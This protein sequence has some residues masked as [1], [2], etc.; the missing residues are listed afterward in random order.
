MET[1]LVILGLGSSGDFY[2]QSGNTSSL[3]RVRSSLAQMASKKWIQ[4][5]GELVK[6]LV[7]VLLRLQKQGGLEFPI[8]DDWVMTDG[9]LG[10]L[11]SVCEARADGLLRTIDGLLETLHWL[12]SSRKGNLFGVD[13]VMDGML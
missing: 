12:L 5:Q 4:W 6:D 3:V 7:D 2:T 13:Q 11:L 10:A 9:L 8:T 1:I